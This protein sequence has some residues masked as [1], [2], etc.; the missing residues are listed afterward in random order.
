[1]GE[2]VANTS[3]LIHALRRASMLV[4]SNKDTLTKLDAICGDGD[5]GVTVGRGF[6]AV[7]ELLRDEK[8]ESLQPAKILESVG[9]AFGRTAASTF[10]VLLA[11]SLV[12][13]ARSM[14]SKD[15]IGGEEIRDMLGA[16]VD[17]VMRRGKGRVGE[18][19]LLDALV[20]AYEAL[21][22]GQAEIASP[23]LALRAAAEA[24]EAGVARTVAMQPLRGRASQLGDRARNVQD[25]GAVAVWLILKG[26]AAKEN[27]GS[28][29]LPGVC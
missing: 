15:S 14:G 18:K 24:A 23:C 4:L 28:V 2:R 5:L 7:Q 19:T 10:G 1:M 20:P 9:A 17:A 22:G 27:G 13:A 11:A 21:L 29:E 26:L 6:S 12:A 8:L 25:P 16:A 3:D